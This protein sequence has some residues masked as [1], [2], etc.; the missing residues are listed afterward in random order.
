MSSGELDALRLALLKSGFAGEDLDALTRPA[1][2][3][4]SS[5]VEPK[6]FKLN[7]TMLHA[8]LSGA[9]MPAQLISGPAAAMS[10]V[11][12]AATSVAAAAG[13]CWQLDA[14]TRKRTLEAAA[15]SGT[16][17]SALEHLPQLDDDPTGVML[18]RVLGG[19]APV[20]AQ[21]AAA[22]LDALSQVTDWIGGTALGKD[23]PKPVELRRLRQRRELIEP[24]L[25][26][27]GRPSDGSADGS[28]DRFVGRQREIERL[29][30]HV[31]IVPPEKMADQIRR[32]AGSLWTAVGF[33]PSRTEPLRIE[34]QGGT[35]KSTLIAK[36]IL[37]HARFMLADAGGPTA[38][39]PFV[40]LDFDRATITAREPLQLLLDMA[41]QIAVWLPETE[42]P[43]ER[44]RL[45]LRKTI[46]NQALDPS[47]KQRE[48]RTWSK[49]RGHCQKFCQIVEA[50]NQSR[51]PVV[52]LFDTFELVQY[53]AE[54]VAGITGLI[55]AIRDQ[56]WPN[57]R[58]IVA[59]RGE[60]LQIKS[61]NVLPLGPLDEKATAELI[62]LRNTRS[63]L[64][65]NDEQVRKLARPLSN[66][67]LD[68]II[69]T[70]WMKENR[71]KA[72]AFADEV[73]RD[74][75]I[76]KEPSGGTE[77]RVTAL[78]V[79][80]MIG[81]IASRAVRDIA[82]P[83]FVVRAI[84][85]ET[86][87]EVMLPPSSGEA[88]PA[89]A[90]AR[91]KALF[92]DLASEH[93]LITRRGDELRHRPEVRRAMLRL[94]RARDRDAFRAANR[95]AVAHFSA[96]ADKGPIERAQ[97]IYHH[98]LDEP[99]AI[100]AADALWRTDVVTDLAAAVDDLSGTAR[101]YLEVKLG[102]NYS[103]DA[104]ARL[105]VAVVRPLFERSGSD[106][107]ERL[108]AEGI[109][110]L[111]RTRADLAEQVDG[112]RLEAL[113]RTG[114]WRELAADPLVARTLE[115]P[116]TRESGIAENVLDYLLKLATRDRALDHWFAPFVLGETLQPP[117]FDLATSPD[118][119]AF[120]A[121]WRR[122][123]GH[124]EQAEL[125]PS[126]LERLRQDPAALRIAAL[127][128]PGESTQLVR[129]ID[130][131]PYLATVSERQFTTFIA[132]VVRAWEALDPPRAAEHYRIAVHRARELAK[133]ER[134]KERIVLDP[135][136]TAEI[137]ALAQMLLAMGPD[138]VAALARR[139]LLHSHPDWL[140][141]L[142]LALDRAYA[143]GV[144]TRLGWFSSVE[145]LLGVDDGPSARA[146]R[147]EN[148][149]QILSLA[150]E[151]GRLGELVES[152]RQ[153]LETQTPQG[154]SSDYDYLAQRFA[155]WLVLLDPSR[156]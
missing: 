106:L 134:R 35:G 104:L 112:A 130:L 37:D 54:A 143:G 50:V 94:M 40:Y 142:G 120:A 75:D 44:F 17:A 61:T 56:K 39:L 87:R 156:G 131:A 97:A 102:H 141:P 144:P 70:R 84:T 18:R 146:G 109:H 121:C 20:A 7:D 51:S 58:I 86:I 65:L 22:E 27:V 153:H 67:P 92:D 53:N 155:E 71:D 107:F 60:M 150:D 136:T 16:L 154:N 89:R 38:R 68:V 23:L 151:A 64:G 103:V 9:F 133:Q 74:E 77:A 111:L 98:L 119:R 88:D 149:R 138:P 148:G 59:G 36:F 10:G 24:F 83:G 127:L 139:F 12:A 57:L 105:P 118:M 81:H 32:G 52:L 63:A 31:G 125:D 30:A 47:H 124:D 147:A 13:R 140:E 26:L 90:V 73:A 25:A 135:E 43:L 3:A 99:P 82:I 95:R 122:R 4:A 85:T 48:R 11:I 49:L 116:E 66:S 42:R 5:P 19:K 110:T 34:G 6:P 101:D 78:L 126:R 80:R 14:E 28:D 15:V 129:L 91:A 76:G 8:A 45:E 132:M 79:D 41:A 46:E 55:D 137:R 33:G 93:W 29:R 113:Y 145:G 108:G 21:L 115:V 100:E 72:A 128:E 152:Y 114:R 123:H 1:Q 96:R 69:V 62:A 2:T 117:R